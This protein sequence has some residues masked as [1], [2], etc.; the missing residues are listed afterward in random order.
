MRV[1]RIGIPPFTNN[2]FV[3]WREY[4]ASS[5]IFT[6]VASCHKHHASMKWIYSYKGTSTTLRLPSCRHRATPEGH[7]LALEEVLAKL[8]QLGVT[9]IVIQDN[10]PDL[11]PQGLARLS[12]REAGVLPDLGR[13]PSTSVGQTVSSWF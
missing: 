13:H 3:S 7:L 2:H 5:F 11:G 6:Q 4:R 10:P 8:I 1:D 9:A 12:G